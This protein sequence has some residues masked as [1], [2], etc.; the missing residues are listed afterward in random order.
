M[1]DIQLFE[2]IKS[3]DLL[4]MKQNELLRR[5][6]KYMRNNTFERCIGFPKVTF[7]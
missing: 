2:L 5:S 7:E 4:F 6:L 3:D 1:S